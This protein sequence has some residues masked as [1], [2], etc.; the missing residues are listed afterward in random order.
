[1]SGTATR[2]PLAPILAQV[3]S[4][5]SGRGFTQHGEVFTRRAGAGVWH[6][7]EFQ[8]NKYATQAN[9]TVNLGVYVEGVNESLGWPVP[10]RNKLEEADCQFRGRLGTIATGKDVWWP[11]DDPHGVAT[12][13]GVALRDKALPLLDLFTSRPQIITA[14]KGKGQGFWPAAVSPRVVAVMLAQEGETGLAKGLLEAELAQAEGPQA[15]GVRK[16]MQ[17]LGWRV[18]E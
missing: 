14:W 13:I 17:R 5:L 4:D 2:K 1:M 11:L 6:V 18:E 3:G 9:F 8:R 12:E 7:V 15:N 16:L 10:D